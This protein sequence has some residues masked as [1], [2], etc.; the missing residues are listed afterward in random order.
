MALRQVMS[1]GVGKVEVR[2]VK[3]P[4]WLLGSRYLSRPE[5]PHS[6]ECRLHRRYFSDFGGHLAL[7]LFCKWK[8]LHRSVVG[9]M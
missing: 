5:T 9:G 7:Q 6:V 8:E 1:N 3:P 2:P 4:G